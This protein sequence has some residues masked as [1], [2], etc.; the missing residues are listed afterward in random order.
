LEWGTV[1]REMEMGSERGGRK[2]SVYK[3]PGTR[4]DWDR[5]TFKG[6]IPSKYE[7]LGNRGGFFRQKGNY[8]EGYQGVIEGIVPCALV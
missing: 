3:Q 6:G 1:G 7:G 5:T 4:V 2:G 8:Q